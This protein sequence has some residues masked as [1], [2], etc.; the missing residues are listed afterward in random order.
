MARSTPLT[1]HA[2]ASYTDRRS[3]KSAC[4]GP[5]PRPEIFALAVDRSGACYCRHLARWQRW[6]RI[7]NGTATEYFGAPNARYIFG[8]LAVSNRWR[9]LRRHGR[10]GQGVPRGQR[11]AWRIWYETGQSHITGLPSIIRTACWPA[12]SPT[13]SCTASRR[14]TSVRAYDASPAGESRHRA[15]G[16]RHGVASRRLGGST[17]KRAQAANSGGPQGKR[18]LWPARSRHRSPTITVGSAVRR[19]SS[20]PIRPNRR[21]RSPARRPHPPRR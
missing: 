12:P 8:S 7:E 11:R 10:A 2:D 13:A 18:G 4:C 16:R 15:H 5:R 1:G 20:R 21:Q 6:Y 19:R 3:T 17:A 14:R 9:A